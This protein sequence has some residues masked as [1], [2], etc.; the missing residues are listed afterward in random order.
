MS[1]G[2]RSGTDLQCD[3]AQVTLSQPFYLHLWKKKKKYEA[4]T[5]PLSH[6][7]DKS[8]SERCFELFDT[9]AS[10]PYCH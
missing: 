7:K 8:M 4:N 3:L 6:S 1:S 10:V 5:R 2:L 9:K